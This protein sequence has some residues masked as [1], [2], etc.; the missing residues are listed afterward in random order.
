MYDV[1]HFEHHM[2]MIFGAKG[3]RK[4]QIFY[5]CTHI[6]QQNKIVLVSIVLGNM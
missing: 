3:L 4:S 6:Q 1:Q 2:C 5:I